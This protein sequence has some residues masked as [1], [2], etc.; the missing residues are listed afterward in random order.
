MKA[1]C[2]ETRARKTLASLDAAGIGMVIQRGRFKVAPPRPWFYDNAVF[3]DWRA[4][5]A[6]DAAKWTEEVPRVLVSTPDFVVLPDIVASP[7]SLAFSLHWLEWLP[8]TSVPLALV[9]QDGMVPSAIPWA[10]RFSLL[11][12]GGTLPWKLDTG[13]MWVEA[14]HEHGRRVHIGRV[15]TAKRVAWAYSA[16]AD[17]IDSSLPL[18]SVEQLRGF[19]RALND[20]AAQS[21]FSWGD[22]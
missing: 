22:A 5:K 17:S 8:D 10:E 16:G 2:G 21:S 19:V 1:Y 3:E 13:R 14:G 9:V 7:D 15:G 4:G 18:W 6:F 20:A 11:F 12:V